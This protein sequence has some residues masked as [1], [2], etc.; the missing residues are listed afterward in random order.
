MLWNP[1][2]LKFALLLK[3]QY[4]QPYG[5]EDILKK[6]KFWNKIKKRKQSGFF[7]EAGA[8]GG[9][10]LS[11]SLYFEVN[12]NWTGLLAEPN[13][14]FHDQ[15]LDKNRWLVICIHNCMSHLHQTMVVGA[16]FWI[17]CQRLPSSSVVLVADNWFKIQRHRP[18]CGVNGSKL[19]VCFLIFLT[20]WTTAQQSFR[21]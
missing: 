20:C 21:K 16:G 1:E 7:I 8:S 11:N 12:H 6:N 19:H 2:I 10:D 15:L 5:V 3:G 18:L 9:E 17:S 14:D 4:G 13:P